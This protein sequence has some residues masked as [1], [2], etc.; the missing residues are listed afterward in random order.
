M[1]NNAVGN[2]KFDFSGKLLHWFD[3]HGRHDLP[4]QKQR[5]PYRVWLSEI[6]LQQT[7]VATVVPYFERFLARFPDVRDLAAASSDDVM[8]L[9][10][11]L[12]YY[13]RA[14]NLHRAAQQIVTAY[15][16]ELPASREALATLP[17]IGRSTAGAILA[18]SRDQ[19]QAI[20]DGNVKRVLTRF[21]GVAGWP[22]DKKV[23][24]Q[25]WQFAEQHTPTT[26]IRD[27]TQAIMDLGAT[28]CTRGRPRCEKC[29]LAE[30]CY[31]HQH[32]STQNFP[33]VKLRK[34][35]PTKRATM[36]IVRDTEQR[37]LLVK[38][39]PIGIWGGLWSLPEH[40]DESSAQQECQRQHGVHCETLGRWPVLH[41]TFSHFHLEITPVLCQGQPVNAVMDGTSASWYNLTQASELGLAAPVR[42]LIA[43][44]QQPTTIADTTT[45]TTRSSHVTKN[46]LRQTQ[47]RS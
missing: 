38:R 9:W 7:Q 44:L 27:Y 8:A 1:V 16:G 43:Q 42:K 11:G 18:I 40:D 37:L 20:L 4:W 2:A 17:G 14:R 41:H 30:Q 19:R 6:M 46:K 36:L 32:N 10:S 23:E 29:P 22:G 35:L 28:V 26:R 47:K 25:L 21:H 45:H 3:H 31:A 33:Q 5:T 13:A 12:G 24:T 15:A 39:P 34:A